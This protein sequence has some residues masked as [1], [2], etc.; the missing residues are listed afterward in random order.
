LDTI[1]TGSVLGYAMKT[2]SFPLKFGKNKNL[3]DAVE[4]IAYKE[5][6]GAE[7]AQ[8]VKKMSEK[9]GKENAMHIKGLEIDAYLPSYKTLGQTLGFLTNPRGACHLNAPTA[10]DEITLFAPLEPGDIKGKPEMIAFLEELNNVMDSMGMCRFTA[11]AFIK[12]G[13][14]MPH[15]IESKTFRNFPKMGLSS[16]DISTY[17]K[18]LSKATGKKYNKKKILEI[19]KNISKW[20]HEFN[21]KAG[22]KIEEESLPES[23]LKN[24]TKSGDVEEGKALLKKML[25]KY[26]K[27]RK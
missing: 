16:I 3:E 27:L 15:S 1:S 6:Y 13:V 10:V 18:L 2:D 26:F 5:K 9:Y 21:R 22:H 20:E 25:D 17:Y 23:M 19:G 24:L 8:G 4:K 11:Y 12:K 7:L 14:G